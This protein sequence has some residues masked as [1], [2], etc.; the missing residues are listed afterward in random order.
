MSN[1]HKPTILLVAGPSGIGK[2][3][4]CKQL[5]RIVPY[6]GYDEGRHTTFYDRVYEATK[7]SDIVLIDMPIKVST[8]IKRNEHLY[9][10]LPAFI[11]EDELTH[12]SRL[13]G[14]GGT[15]KDSIISR[16][17]ALRRRALKYAKF[18]GTSIQVVHWLEQEVISHR[19]SYEQ[20]AK[21]KA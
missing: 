13:E 2:S 1:E 10:I 6:V 19:T 11:E 16:R 20:E 5:A 9:N 17:E 18:V 8:F 14:R 21:K 12:K 4:V 15:W 3:W 7:T